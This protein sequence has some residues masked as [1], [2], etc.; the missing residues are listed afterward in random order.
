MIAEN[1]DYDW[2]T[3][4]K[5][6]RRAIQLDPGYATAHQWHAEYLA[7]LGRFDEALAESALARQL[8]PLSL[9]IAT[10]H[11]SILY[12]AR[13]YDRAI[14]QCRT[15][16]DMDKNFR[17]ASG[18]L[19]HSYVQTSRFEEALHEVESWTDDPAVPW[20]WGWKAYVYGRWGRTTDAEH[21]L[22]K[23]E[24]LLSGYS[25]DPEPRRV[26]PYIATGRTE[27]AILLLER[28]Y[29]EHSPAIPALKTDPMYDPLRADPRFQQLLARVIGGANAN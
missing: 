10:D 9:I 4:K 3:A 18:I 16:P 5:E 15:V 23:F 25:K 11:A 13:Q 24:Q 7:W 2:Q 26:L 20:V 19:I 17:R 21:A 27:Q 12:L 8:D 22:A 1:Y 28:L 6:F 29:S 14:A